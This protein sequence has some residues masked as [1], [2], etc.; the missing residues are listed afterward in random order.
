MEVCSLSR[1][2]CFYSSPSHSRMAFACSIFLCP[3]S[4][5]PSLRTAFPVAGRL[6]VFSFF[7]SFQKKG[8]GPSFCPGVGGCGGGERE[9]PSLS[10]RP[11]SLPP[12]ST[13]LL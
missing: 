7:F 6:R 13:L 8:G 3:Q 2:V 12:L 9:P 10:P 1:G 11:F 4:H 5:R